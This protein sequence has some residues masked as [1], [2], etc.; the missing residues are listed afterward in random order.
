VERRVSEG[1]PRAAL[2]E[3]AAD[4]QMI[5]VGARGRG[6]FEE[7]SIGS[8]GLAVLAYARCP[9]GVEHPR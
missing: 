2:L 1:S 5:I 4:A 7:M 8:V 6:G 3:A 9:V